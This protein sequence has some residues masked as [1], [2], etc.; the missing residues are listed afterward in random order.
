[1][2]FQYPTPSG[3]N[4]LPTKLQY[5]E[6]HTLTLTECSSNFKG[7]DAIHRLH[8]SNVCTTN[9]MGKGACMGDSGE[10]FEDFFFE[11]KFT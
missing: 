5:K 3:Q 10:L 11:T 2:Y 9:P 6:T 7:L 1:M 8:E 4:E